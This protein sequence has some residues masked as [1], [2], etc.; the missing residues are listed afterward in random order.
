MA[1]FD[2]HHNINLDL[3]D[4]L[5]QAR[6]TLRIQNAMHATLVL[7][8]VLA[9]ATAVFAFPRSQRPLVATAPHPQ[10]TWSSSFDGLPACRSEGFFPSPSSCQHFYRCAR[11]DPRSSE[12]MRYQFECPQD[13]IYCRTQI[14]CV[15]PWACSEKC[16]IQSHGEETGKLLVSNGGE[17][18]GSAR[19]VE[20]PPFK[21]ARPGTF[22]D[23]HDCSR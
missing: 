4:F 21:C 9:A 1:T 7:S 15:H 8:A 18:G 22:T 12:L 13:Q 19:K 3:A 2:R 14:A 5:D 17:R 16:E 10:E 23:P 20:C 11:A 6:K